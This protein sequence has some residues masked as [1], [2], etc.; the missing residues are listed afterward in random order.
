MKYDIILNNKYLKTIE[1]DVLLDIK[2][3]DIIYMGEEE[4]VIIFYRFDFLTECFIIKIEN[5][6]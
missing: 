4:F 5:I 3:S 6:K 1:S 2:V